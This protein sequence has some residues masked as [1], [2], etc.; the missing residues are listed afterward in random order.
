MTLDCRMERHLLILEC[1]RRKSKITKPIPAWNRYI[2]G[3]FPVL[4]YLH[5]QNMLPSTIDIMV[6]SAKYG[7]IE[8]TELIDNYDL[9]L[10]RSISVNLRE[11]VLRKLKHKLKQNRYSSVLLLIEG[12][13]FEPLRGYEV[14]LNKYNIPYMKAHPKDSLYSLT[15]W[16]KQFLYPRE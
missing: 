7:L 4:K 9:K 14:I 16:F 11:K 8:V 13:Y 12:A 15:Y 3:S 1:T 6:I 2:G 5:K 10:T